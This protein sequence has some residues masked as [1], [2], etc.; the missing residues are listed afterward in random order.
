MRTDRKSNGV[1]KGSKFPLRSLINSR[2]FKISAL[3]FPNS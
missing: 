1:L 3:A 2:R